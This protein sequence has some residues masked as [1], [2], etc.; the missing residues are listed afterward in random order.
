MF[1][2]ETVRH[3]CRSVRTFRHQSHGAEMSRVRGVLGPKCL[4]TS[5]TAQCSTYA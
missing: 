1:A 5:N 3:R 2:G 4:D